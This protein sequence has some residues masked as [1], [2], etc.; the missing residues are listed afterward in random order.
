[1]D[2]TYNLHVHI[3]ECRYNAVQFTRCYYWYCNDKNI[4]TDT[5]HLTL[6]GE[7]WGVNCEDSGENWPR[8]HGTA[9]YVHIDGLVQGRRNSNA[10]APEPRPPHQPID[11]HMYPK[12]IS[13][14]F[15]C[16][17]ALIIHGTPS[18]VFFIS[19]S[20]LCH[21]CLRQWRLTTI[22]PWAIAW[23]RDD[24]G[25]LSSNS[26]AEKKTRILTVS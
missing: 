7:M 17:N 13:S 9:L 1:M 23:A 8:Q 12:I 25:V 16:I 24:Q 26:F 15:T 20:I 21:Q 19:S 18:K 5:P 2:S 3:V 22:G 4:T 10:I 14:V 6:M 11:I